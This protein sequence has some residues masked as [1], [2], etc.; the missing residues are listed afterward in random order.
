MKTGMPRFSKSTPTIIDCI[1]HPE[2]WR[3]WFRDPST[4]QP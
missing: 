4:W 1:D 2:I 3:G